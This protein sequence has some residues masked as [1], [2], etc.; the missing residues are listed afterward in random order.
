ML[1]GLTRPQAIL[2]RSWV[3]V[4]ETPPGLSG[5]EVEHLLDSLWPSGSE[6][7]PMNMLGV[8][9]SPKFVPGA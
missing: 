3:M 4:C 9:P 2:L 6:C 1:A 5:A 7:Q 8:L